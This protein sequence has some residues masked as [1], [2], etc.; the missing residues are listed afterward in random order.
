VPLVEGRAVPRSRR[1]LRSDL[2]RAGHELRQARDLRAARAALKSAEQAV[3]SQGKP[4]ARRTIRAGN[5]LVQR[6]LRKV[7]VLR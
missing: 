6:V 2:K 3:S 7:R 1:S 5:G 4:A